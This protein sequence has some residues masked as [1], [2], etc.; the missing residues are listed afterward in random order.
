MSK[1]YYCPRCG[2]IESEEWYEINNTC[3]CD[4]EFS[5]FDTK[6]RPIEEAY[7]DFDL[8]KPMDIYGITKDM[9]DL[10]YEKY[11]N[12][13]QNKKLNVDAAR[14]VHESNEEF[15]AS[16]EDCNGEHIIDKIYNSSAEDYFV[17]LTDPYNS[18]S[19]PPLKPGQCPACLSTM[20]TTRT[21]CFDPAG[22]VIGS[23]FFG[24]KG[25]IFGAMGEERTYHVC[26]KCGH[27][28]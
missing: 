9:S 1:I 14:K 26:Q 25:A 28:W 16:G 10:V 27:K 19:A 13:P 3:S 18:A 5:I 20:V 23:S 2:K 8:T 4:K 22:A 21:T 6:M 24:E 15:Y 7:E 17:S 12:I 11:V